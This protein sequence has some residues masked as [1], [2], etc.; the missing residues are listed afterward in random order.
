MSKQVTVEDSYGRRT[1]FQGDLL[2]DDT[3]DNGD[4]P[5]WLD[6][7]IWRTEG[8]S[9]VVRK[10]VQYRVIHAR[11]NCAR[12]DGFETRPVDDEDTIPCHICNPEGR[13]IRPGIAQEARITVDVYKEPE[14]LIEGLKA[15]GEWT[16]L[17]RSLLAQL[18]EKDERIDRL[19]NTVEVD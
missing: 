15:K 12:L 13:I 1:V 6:I 9:F 10:D 11:R 7:Y 17:S 18:S 2:I 8:G 19:W 14:E 3:T 16:R 4:K 5:Q